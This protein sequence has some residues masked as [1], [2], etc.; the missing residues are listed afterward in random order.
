M[1][2]FMKWSILRT[3]TVSATLDLHHMQASDEGFSRDYALLIVK[4]YIGKMIPDGHE[5]EYDYLDFAIQDSFESNTTQIM[6]SADVT[7]WEPKNI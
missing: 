4:D 3:Q 5:F 2:R 1:A 6:F 7:V